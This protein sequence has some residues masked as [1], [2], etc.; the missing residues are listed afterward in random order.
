VKRPRKSK[1]VGVLSKTFQILELVR[2]SAAPLSLKEIS[3]QTAIN[4][5]TALRILAHLEAAKYL[6]R[7]ARSEYSIGAAVSLSGGVANRQGTLR[8][9]ARPELWDL[10]HATQETVNLAMLDGTE[11][12]YL[13]CLESAHDFRL[14]AHVGM[15]AVVYRTALGKAMLAFTPP[16]TLDRVLSSLTFQPFTPKTI[17][18]PEAYRNALAKA[19]KEGFAVDDQE[20]HIGL[21][22]IAAPILNSHQEAVAAISVSGPTGRV[23]TANVRAMGARVKQSAQAISARFAVAGID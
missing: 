9:L 7:N 18:S 19:R 4:K 15:R 12:V 2:K 1:P 17:I 3:E 14:V 13:E 21:R 23:T 8:R 6:D 11:V 20:S 16:E 10:W 5:S 22:C